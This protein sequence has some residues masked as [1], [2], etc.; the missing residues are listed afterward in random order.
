[1]S[2]LYFIGTSDAVETARTAR[3]NRSISATAQG[4]TCGGTVQGYAKG[5][6]SVDGFMISRTDGRLH[7]DSPHCIASYSS[8]SPRT[9][10]YP[11]AGDIVHLPNGY[12]R[13][14]VGA[15][16]ILRPLPEDSPE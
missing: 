4:Q 1:M 2:R 16:G 9:N 11:K 15:D 10:F 14:Q 12:G 5:Q 13:L 3:G 7:A 8:D 6:T